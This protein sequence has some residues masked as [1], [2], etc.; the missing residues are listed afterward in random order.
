MN[1]LPQRSSDATH[2][3]LPL[4]ADQIYSVCFKW[5]WLRLGHTAAAALW[6]SMTGSD[7]RSVSSG[8]RPVESSEFHRVC[9]ALVL[10]VLSFGSWELDV[11]ALVERAH[12]C[13]CCTNPTFSCCIV[14][15]FRSKTLRYFNSLHDHICMQFHTYWYC[16][17]WINC[18]HLTFFETPNTV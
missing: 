10:L 5:R 12:D 8:F 11:E 6:P 9:P 17:Y 16:V 13:S 1:D 4:A 7:S 14:S 3:V 18:V 15:S 2:C